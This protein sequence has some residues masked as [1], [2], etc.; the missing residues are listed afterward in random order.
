MLIDEG[1]WEQVQTSGLAPT[2]QSSST[3]TFDKKLLTFGGIVNGKAV[4]SLHLLDLCKF[5]Q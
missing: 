1:V 2:A 5:H 3:V 4:N